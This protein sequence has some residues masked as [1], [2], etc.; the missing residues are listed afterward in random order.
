MDKTNIKN[1]LTSEQQKL[2]KE[3]LYVIGE[4]LNL[5]EKV[6][7]KDILNYSDDIT[8]SFYVDGDENN[9]LYQCW[10]SYDQ[11]DKQVIF[12]G[13]SQDKEKVKPVRMKFP[14]KVVKDFGEK[15]YCG[16]WISKELFNHFGKDEVLDDFYSDL[17]GYTTDYTKCFT[18]VR[19]KYD[20][21]PFVE[22]HQRYMNK[23]VN[24][25]YGGFHLKQLMKVVN[26][27]FSELGFTLEGNGGMVKFDWKEQNGKN[28]SRRIF[29]NL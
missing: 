26:E 27:K 28:I 9:Y 6:R 13:E 4:K 10:F 25:V 5:L 1:Q 23:L 3:T 18:I 24:N 8:S 21:E 2:M 11:K 12:C 19:S 7:V 29:K 17:V 16:V 15:E 22:Y 20:G 14:K